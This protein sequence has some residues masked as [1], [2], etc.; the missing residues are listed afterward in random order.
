MAH[1]LVGAVVGRLAAGTATIGAVTPAGGALAGARVSA[2]LAMTG[3]VVVP[4]SDPTAT[5]FHAKAD[6]EWRFAAMLA[7]LTSQR[8]QDQVA[9]TWSDYDGDRMHVVQQKGNGFV[10]LWIP[11]HPELKRLLDAR[12]RADRKRTP[13]PLTIL[14]RPDGT[15]WPVNAF[16][17]AAGKAIRAAGLE[18]VVWHGLRATAMS[19]A[20]EGGASQRQLMSLSGHSTSAMADHYVRGA[21]QEKMA[22]DAL[23]AIELPAGVER[24]RHKTAKQPGQRLPSTAKSAS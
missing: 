24:K 9:M 6:P 17:K 13:T 10:K 22:G 18:G 15:P 16:Q 19:W 21:N 7:L 20:A 8:G 5:R 12:R 1:H 2:V 23:K 4:L 3:L 11:A 14:S